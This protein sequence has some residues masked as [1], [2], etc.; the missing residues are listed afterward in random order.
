MPS[1]SK[2]SPLPVAPPLSSSRLELLAPAGDWNALKAGLAAGAD[3]IYLGGKSFSARQSASNFDRTQLQEAADLIHLQRRKIYVTVNT[4]IRESE[5]PEAMEFLA[6]LYNIGIDAVIV[7]DLGLIARARQL[8]PQLELHASTQM[9][10]HNRE[11]ALAL[12]E[13]G[14]RRIVLARELTGEEV[15]SI[16]AHTGME[17]EVFV[18]GALCVCYSGQCLMSSMIGGRSGNRGRCA[19]PCRLEYQLMEDGLGLPAQ[20]SYLLSPKDLALA[21]LV[22]EL[23]RAGVR[24][25]KIEGRMKRP[26]YVYGVVKVYRRL[27]DRFFAQPDAYHVEQRDREE[28]EQAFNRGFSTGYFGGQ[29]N[30]GIA[31]LTRPNNR[32]V[33]LG[34]IQAVHR[35]AGGEY[36]AN[37]VKVTIK[38]EASL[39]S[40]DEVEVW[41][42]RGGRQAGPVHGLERGGPKIAIANPGETVA[43]RFSGK[44]GPGDRV[45]KVFSHRLHEE[46]EN[47]LAENN[48]DL[49][50]PITAYLEGRLDSPLR[51]TFR[52]PCGDSGAAVSATPLQIART[53]P[54]TREIVAA[55]LG[56]LGNTPFR[57][58]ALI[59]DLD[60]NVMAPLRDLNQ[61]R[62]QALEQLEAVKL[63]PYRRE[64]IDWNLATSR[65]S[66]K[67]SPLQHI[68]GPTQGT[69]PVLSAWV[70]DLE[71]VAAVAPFVEQ[72]YAGGD[73]LTGF[74]W[75]PDAL[76]QARE[77]AHSHKTRFILGLPRINREAHHSQWHALLDAALSVCPDGIILSE[78]GS[79][80][81]VLKESVL[82]IYLNYTLNFFNSAALQGLGKDRVRQ[83]TLSP[84]LSL[85]EIRA[86]NHSGGRVG[87]LL[88]CLVQGPLELMVSE[89]CP[90]GTIKGESCA[91]QCQK[92]RFA[93]RDRLDLDFPILTDQFC[94]MHLLNCKELCMYGDL[95]DLY[96]LGRLGW[97]LELKTHSA[98]VAGDIAAQYRRLLEGLKSGAAI[99][100]P[101]PVIED[102]IRMTGRGITKGHFFR[103]V[104]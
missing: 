29:R 9:T 50:I 75:T 27:L 94:R 47:A 103:G 8:L 85:A 88:E 46:T 11:G 73:E 37:A 13:M 77:I 61:L 45:F 24:S 56:R 41:I 93:L 67:D 4:L 62:R 70:A 96:K 39:E 97:R 43:F 14:L 32:G 1:L 71:S 104:E 100:D 87:P 26:E 64:K 59:T 99:P 36:G 86:L 23:F 10:V 7:Q 53:R 90:I 22:P 16:A 34:R 19:Q 65:I 54:L 15:A 89:Y 91:L 21:E 63:A 25:L 17:L 81:R 44:I 92:R 102:F 66:V 20:G 48:P 72:I 60:S 40:G 35:E 80:F 51:L 28:L 18:H 30:K 52:D 3:A 42:S 79:F 12:K 5:L 95:P 49:K 31:G 101:T 6:E 2:T 38:L 57:L 33:Y 76:K 82:D 98:G 68:P 78:L 69:G 83:V 84:E 55:Q 58:E 74:H